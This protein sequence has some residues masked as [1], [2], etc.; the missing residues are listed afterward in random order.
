MIHGYARPEIQAAVTEQVKLG[1]SFGVATESRGHAIPAFAQPPGAL[2]V[3]GSPS[4]TIELLP[5]PANL[6][7]RA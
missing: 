4:G 7:L 5:A 6:E 3:A 2:M 1:S